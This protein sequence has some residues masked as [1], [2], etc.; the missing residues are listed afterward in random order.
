MTRLSVAVLGAPD[1][2]QDRRPI[3]FPTRKSLALFLYVLTEGGPQPRD[4][5]AALFWPESDGAAARATLRSTVARLR[6]AL[7]GLA[8]QHLIVDRTAVTF[9]PTPE[10][11]FDLDALATAYAAA[12][13]I[14]DDALP[15]GEDRLTAV[16][17]LERG[18]DAWRGEFLEGF[19]LPDAPD[20]DD[21]AGL[22]REL[23]R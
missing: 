2:R 5:L 23:W 14:T 3:I 4:T 22:Q 9:R 20:F 8:D 21:W 10:F 19:S 11:A 7:D 16:D 15:I 18:A 13:G 12:G 6:E 17:R 1:V